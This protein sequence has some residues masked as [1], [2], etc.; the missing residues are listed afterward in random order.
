MFEN[1]DIY[2]K[3]FYYFWNVSKVSMC[4]RFRLILGLQYSVSNPAFTFFCSS[5]NIIQLSICE[6]ILTWVKELSISDEKDQDFW[7][8]D[9]KV[10][11]QQLKATQKI[12]STI[13]LLL[14]I[15]RITSSHFVEMNILPVLQFMVFISQ[16]INTLTYKKGNRETY[17]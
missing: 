16:R 8:S 1:Y 13:P 3:S 5:S 15:L 11:R 17:V 12:S 6:K 10:K 7:Q 4:G 2:F 9:Y 14:Y